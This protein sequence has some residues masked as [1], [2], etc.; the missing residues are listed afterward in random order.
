MDPR[1]APERIRFRHPTDE[2]PDVAG[3]SWPARPSRAALPPPVQPE[4]LAVP[5]DHRLGL[6]DRQRPSPVPPE[7]EQQEPEESIRS[8]E[9]WLL[10]SPLQHTELMPQRQV[11]DRQRSLR[12]EGRNQSAE[13]DVEHGSE[14]I[15]MLAY[16]QEHQGGPGL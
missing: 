8:P 14:A 11:L 1:G 2:I 15:G 12:L 16:L 7:P 9:A 10:G 13:N 5:P 6:N 3:D 4:P